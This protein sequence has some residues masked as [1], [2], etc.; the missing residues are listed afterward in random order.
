MDNVPSCPGTMIPTWVT[1]NGTYYLTCGA[2]LDPP[3][4]VLVP[5]GLAVGVL[6]FW[7]GV[8]LW[9]DFKTDVRTRNLR[10]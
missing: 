6:A 7:I 3:Y 1:N 10:D 8:A 5:V 2:S 4:D 9:V